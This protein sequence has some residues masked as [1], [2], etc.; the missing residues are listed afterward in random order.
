MEVNVTCIQILPF[1]SSESAT[2]INAKHGPF[3]E[4]LCLLKKLSEFIDREG[5]SWV[6][7]WSWEF[8]S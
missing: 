3:P 2:V 1:C 5:F 7:V 6:F 4:G 8:Q